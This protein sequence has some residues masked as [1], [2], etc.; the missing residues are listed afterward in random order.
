MRALPGA[1]GPGSEQGADSGSPSPSTPPDSTP[2]PS[3]MPTPPPSVMPTPPPSMMPAPAHT[4]C[5]WLDGDDASNVSFVANASWFNAVHPKWYQVD[6]NGNVIPVSTPDLPS[7]VN[8]AHANHV[9]LMPMIDNPDADRLR[10]IFSS[11][12]KIAAHV[13]TLVQLVQTSTATTAWTS[14][15]STCGPR[16]TG[17]DFSA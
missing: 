2:P 5:G 13:Q 17:R 11:Q 9:K 14:T 8:A 10:L 3:V 6:P 1:G 12:S 4:R 7:V 15:T 16:P